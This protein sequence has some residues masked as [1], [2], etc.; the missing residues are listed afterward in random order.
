MESDLYATAGPCF[1]KVLAVS[2]NDYV[3]HYEL[4]IVYQHLGRPKEALNHLQIACGLA[5]HS[6]QCRVDLE[7]LQHPAN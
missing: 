5:P 6:E 3:S 7:K 4:G 2:G 1:E